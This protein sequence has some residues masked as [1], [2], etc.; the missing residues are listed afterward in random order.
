MKFEFTCDL[1]FHPEIAELV[2]RTVVYTVDS[3]TAY[4]SCV[5]FANYFYCTIKSTDYRFFCRAIDNREGIETKFDKAR[6]SYDYHTHEHHM[7]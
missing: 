4:C 7:H 3:Q 5:I 1:K 2:P 6:V